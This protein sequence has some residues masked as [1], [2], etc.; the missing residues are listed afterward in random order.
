MRSSQKVWTAA[1][2]TAGIDLALALVEDD[3]GTEIAQTVARWLVLQFSE[4]PTVFIILAIIG[5]FIFIAVTAALPES[6]P[7]EKRTT[8]GLK[9]TLQTF[10]L[11]LGDRSFMGFAFS[12]AFILTGMFAYISGS[13]FV[14]QNIFGVSAQMFSFLFAVN[15]AGIIA[16]TQIT[17]RLAAKRDERALFTFGL[18]LSI[19]GS[20]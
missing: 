19:I 1:G 10:R 13:P 6:L 5:F 15:G 9:E 8:G 2:V 14:L 17:G 12:Q 16:A 20:I 11:L 18:I 7:I 3:H 4:W